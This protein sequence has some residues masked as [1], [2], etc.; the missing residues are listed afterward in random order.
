MTKDEFQLRVNEL[1]PPREWPDNYD[2]DNRGYYRDVKLHNTYKVLI[3]GG[4]NSYISS[5]KGLDKY[6]CDCWPIFHGDK[7]TL[8]YNIL[9]Y[10][11]ESKDKEEIRIQPLPEKTQPGIGDEIKPEL[12]KQ[13]IC[14]W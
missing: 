7:T 5:S 1:V 10:L 4:G 14:D 9:A 3:Y 13:R 11:W 6:L 2:L 12:L 8:Y